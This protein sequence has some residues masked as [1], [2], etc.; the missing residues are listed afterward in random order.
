[1][2]CNIDAADFLDLAEDS[3]LTDAGG[4][5]AGAA[6]FADFG[7]FAVD[8]VDLPVFAAL[9]TFFAGAALAVFAEVAVFAFFAAR[10][11]C[12]F[13]LLFATRARNLH[14]QRCFRQIHHKWHDNR[15]H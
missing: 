11:G 3:A 15:K 7:A 9:A 13:C 1:M 6:D 10:A 14:R 8:L 12:R 5:L 4:V 2:F